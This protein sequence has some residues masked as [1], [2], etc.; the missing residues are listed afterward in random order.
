MKI[1]R[2]R[3]TAR[4]VSSGESRDVGAVAGKALEVAVIAAA[5]RK[6][7]GEDRF[8]ML[9]AML[10]FRSWSWDEIE[11]EQ[12]DVVVLRALTFAGGPAAQLEQQRIGELR[13]GRRRAGEKFL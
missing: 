11:D 2:A 4:R 10:G 8:R 3:R 9:L 5:L 12:S 13:G 6:S 1:E 7:T